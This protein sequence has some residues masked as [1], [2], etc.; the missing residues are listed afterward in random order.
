MDSAQPAVVFTSLAEMCV[1]AFSDRCSIV[2]EEDDDLGYRI[3]RSVPGPSRNSMHHVIRMPVRSEPLPGARQFHGVVVYSWFAGRRPTYAD[4]ALAQLMVE[5]A[6]AAVHHERLSGRGGA[7]ATPAEVATSGPPRRTSR[8]TGG[9]PRNGRNLR[10]PDCPSAY[11]EPLQA[12]RTLGADS[13]PG[14]GR[15]ADADADPAGER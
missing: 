5:R 7:E 13:G 11:P 4:A 1:P 14:S 2:I 10:Y 12:Q 3:G 6:I 9:G 8:S 15:D